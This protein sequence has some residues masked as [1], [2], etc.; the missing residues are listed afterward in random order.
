MPYVTCDTTPRYTPIERISDEELHFLID[1]EVQKVPFIYG[2]F[3]LYDN[4]GPIF[5]GA[6]TLLNE[7][8]AARGRHPEATRF[9]LKLGFTDYRSTE[10]LVE[11]LRR[12]CGLADVQTN[13]EP[14]GFHL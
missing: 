8:L 10:Q 7:L 11:M 9:S 5:V 4:T 12:E 2:V 14:I 6:G 13:K 1:S 3:I